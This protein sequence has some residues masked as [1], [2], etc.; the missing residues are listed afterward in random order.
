MNT[1][2]QL[3]TGG[4]KTIQ[5]G[6]TVKSLAEDLVTIRLCVEDQG[7]GRSSIGPPRPSYLLLMSRWHSCPAIKQNEPNTKRVSDDLVVTN[8]PMCSLTSLT[9]CP[10]VVLDSEFVS[11]DT[12]MGSLPKLP[13]LSSQPKNWLPSVVGVCFWLVLERFS[14]VLE[15]CLKFRLLNVFSR[16][17]VF[18]RVS[19]ETW[20]PIVHTYRRFTLF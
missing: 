8:E 20:R 5:A 19:Q 10:F 2:R 14:H 17:P 9:T 11:G 15:S 6:Q 18:R 4:D 7:E 16:T 12:T 13:S 1:K 3:P